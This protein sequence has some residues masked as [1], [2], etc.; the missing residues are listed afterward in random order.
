MQSTALRSAIH[1]VLVTP[2]DYAHLARFLS[3]FANET[4]PEDFWFRRFNFWWDVNPAHREGVPRGWVLLEGNDIKG[5]LG[6]VPTEFQLSGRAVTAF[7]TTTWRVLPE[8][9]NHSLRLLYSFLGCA[10][11]SIFF[12]TTPSVDV[13]PV[14]KGFKF[15]LLTY[16]KRPR[17][18]VIMLN[19]LRVLKSK[20]REKLSTTLTAWVGAP[21]ARTFQACRLRLGGKSHTTETQELTRADSSFDELWLKTRHLYA[22]TNVRTAAVINWQCFGSPDFRK[23]LFG[24]FRGNLLAGFLIASAGVR[25]GL[26]V[27]SCLDLWLDPEVPSALP[28]LL[29]FTQRWAR[30]EGFDLVEIRHFDDSLE[31]QL[32]SIGLFWRSTAGEQPAYYRISKHGALDPAGSYLVGLQGDRGL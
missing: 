4:R 5:F 2:A 30:G 14:L 18:S 3:N 13:V 23:L 26:K 11:A 16:F 31:R 20:S 24:C 29:G 22:N 1:L 19:P 7:N 27:L 32:T 10:E 15:H 8:Y 21:V 28:D 9:R 6:N 12:D 17:K 25:N